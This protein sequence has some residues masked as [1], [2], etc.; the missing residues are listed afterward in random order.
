[1]AEKECETNGE[2][3]RRRKDGEKERKIER[4]KKDRQTDK[5]EGV[6][7]GRVR[8]ARVCERD[9]DGAL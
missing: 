4:E 8:G 5:G 1:M 7:G 2:R 3:Y 9:K 6:K